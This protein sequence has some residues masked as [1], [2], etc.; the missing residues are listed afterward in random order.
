MQLP[1]SVVGR[2]ISSFHLTVESARLY[3][4]F[5]FWTSDIIIVAVPKAPIPDSE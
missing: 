5:F 1:I 4:F 3:D 2:N